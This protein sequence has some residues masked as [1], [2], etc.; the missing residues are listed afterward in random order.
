MR[1]AVVRDSDGFVENVIEIKANANW[2]IPEGHHLVQAKTSGSPGDT[3]D[4][5]D[6]V[7]PAPVPVELTALERLEARV[8]ALEA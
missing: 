4:G 8:K 6:F 3:W 1:K 5:K 7:R 2:P